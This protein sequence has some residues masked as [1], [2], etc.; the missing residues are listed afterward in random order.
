[1]RGTCNNSRNLSD[2]QLRRIAEGGGLVGIGFWPQAVCGNDTAAIA[3]A[4]KHAV[5]IAG[6][7]H[8]ALGSDFD[9]AVTVPFDASQSGELIQSLIDAGLDRETLKAVMSGNAMRF[10]AEALPPEP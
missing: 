3:R 7:E 5:N 10:L 9:G 2:D 1:V 6:A 8:V 4:V